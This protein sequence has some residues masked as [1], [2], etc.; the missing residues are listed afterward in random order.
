MATKI[1]TVSS[2]R[3]L[4]ARHAP[5]WQKVRAECHLGF[6]KT[7][8]ES[9]GAWIARYRDTNGK[10]Q[11]HSLGSLE[12][13]TGANRYV[14]AVKRAGE[15]FDHRAGGGSNETVTLEQACKRYVQKARDEGRD[16]AAK[17]LEGR[18]ARWV[19]TDK[20]LSATP[21]PK[22][23]AAM[24]NDWRKMLVTTPAKLQDKTK[25]AT[26]PRAASSVNREMAVLKA[27]LNLALED[28][29]A[30]TDTAWKVKLKPIKDAAGRR[31]CYLDP[32]QRK[33]LIA[34]APADLAAL[35]TALSLLPLR[36]G[37]VAALI[38]ASYDK[39]QGVLTIGKDKA[40]RDRKIKLPTSTAAF[41]AEQA[42]DKL[43]TAPLFARADGQFWNKDAW[44]YPFKDAAKAAGLPAEAVT[45]NL[46]HSAI[47]D[48]IALHHLD[49]MTVAVL[50]GTSLAMIEKHY[51]HLLQ[52]H[53][54]D[55]LAKLAL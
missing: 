15:W 42:K 17:D 8:P 41:F 27:A 11:L 47:T 48:L 16:K 28:G 43:P 19:Y 44:K 50:S 33:A 3:D 9:V 2:R 31:D 26:E 32:A 18:F 14:E 49:T 54:A 52:G 45:Y 13:I 36:P 30:T 23:T 39:R 24:L 35:I 46:R 6:R 20:K 12:T 25:T 40:G 21:V 55:A 10:Y 29:Y 1:D 51:G 4:K 22:L 53:A 5:Y 37:A 7:T 38:V 34:H